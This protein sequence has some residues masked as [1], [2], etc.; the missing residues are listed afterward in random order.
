MASTTTTTARAQ[1]GESSE[2]RAQAL[3]PGRRPI[4]V[5]P[6]RIVGY[7]LLIFGALVFVL[8][9]FWMVSTSLQSVGDITRGRAVPS[10]PSL[11]VTQ[12]TEEE[13]N[14]VLQDLLD[15]GEFPSYRSGVRGQIEHSN[16]QRA[17]TVD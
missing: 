12:V 3:T 9:F 14:R 10:I 1:T 13:L 8:P 2:A 4:V 16:R 6:F 7:V 11:E 5:N 15:S 17:L